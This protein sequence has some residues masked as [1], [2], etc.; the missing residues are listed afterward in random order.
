VALEVTAKDRKEHKERGQPAVLY[1]PW[2]LLRLEGGVVIRI[3]KGY[4]LPV[5]V[6]A[7]F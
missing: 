2:I 7:F 4:G 6:A 5:Y 3:I 1:V